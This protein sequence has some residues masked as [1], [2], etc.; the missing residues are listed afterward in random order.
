M[1]LPVLADVVMKGIFGFGETFGG[2]TI[3][4][5]LPTMMISAASLELSCISFNH[6]SMLR[7]ESGLLRS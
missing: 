6:D 1:L 3:S 5:L 7:R 2:D 4:D